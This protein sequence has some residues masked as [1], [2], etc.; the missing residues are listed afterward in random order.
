MGEDVF[1][2]ES[3]EREKKITE[4]FVLIAEKEVESAGTGDSS[5]VL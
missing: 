3:K 1:L 4:R 2:G 5:P